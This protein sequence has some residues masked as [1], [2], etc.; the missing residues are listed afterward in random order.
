MS[1]RAVYG[2]HAGL[3]SEQKRSLVLALALSAVAG[4]IGLGLAWAT[5]DSESEATVYHA[6]AKDLTGAALS[7]LCVN[8]TAYESL[9]TN[10]EENEVV[11][12]GF[13]LFYV[14]AQPYSDRGV[15]CM[16]GGSQIVELSPGVTAEEE[17]TR[18]LLVSL[19]GES[20]VTTQDFVRQL[21][22]SSVVLAMS[23]G[24]YGPL[25]ATSAADGGDL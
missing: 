12:E 25:T 19:T 5:A 20:E 3:S 13:E 17:F 8:N 4:W 24:P 9:G 22:Q 14:G 16:I 7:H 23:A 15:V 21:Q 11:R 6:S 2:V 18:W 10:S 1:K